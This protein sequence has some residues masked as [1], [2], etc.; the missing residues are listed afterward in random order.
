MS[1]T[2]DEVPPKAAPVLGSQAA[3]EA[4]S[5]CSETTGDPGR[6]PPGANP[7]S[8]DLFDKRDGKFGEAGLAVARLMFLATRYVRTWRLTAR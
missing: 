6:A 2:G 7:L 5:K 1:E 3:R 4:G 8:L